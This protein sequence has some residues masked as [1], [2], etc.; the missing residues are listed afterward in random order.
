MEIKEIEAVLAYWEKQD[1]GGWSDATRNECIEYI[2]ENPNT[3]AWWKDFLI[4][5]PIDIIER[6]QS[7]MKKLL[8]AKLI[9]LNAYEFELSVLHEFTPKELVRRGKMFAEW[10]KGSCFSK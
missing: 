1:G 3:L 9:D 10:L 7:L 2:A 5:V 6:Y 4:Y 8:D